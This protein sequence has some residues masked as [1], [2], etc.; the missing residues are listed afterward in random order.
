MA[1]AQHRLNSNEQQ[2]LQDIYNAIN[3]SDN[4]NDL[5]KIYLQLA[6]W[7]IIILEFLKNTS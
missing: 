5:E 1:S 7:F 4:D 2:L 6:N 3:G